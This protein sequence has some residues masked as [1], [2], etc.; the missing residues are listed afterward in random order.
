MACCAELLCHRFLTMDVIFKRTGERRYAVNVEV[1]GRAPQVMDP[2][3]GYDEHIPHDLVHYVVE[4]ELS[5]RAGVFGRA[6]IGGGTFIVTAQDRQSPRARARERRRQLRRESRLCATDDA[7]HRD[8]LTSE[9]LA[10]I[11]DLAWRR[12]HGQTPDPSRWK[13]SEPLS[14]EDAARVERVVVRLDELARAWRTLP[15]GGQLVFTWPS[16]S[17]RVAAGV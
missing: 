2:A 15:V 12:R 16:L 4:A 8:M 9:R 10:S 1:P 5:L 17:A 6:A 13:P 14:R 7:R 11:C 3:P